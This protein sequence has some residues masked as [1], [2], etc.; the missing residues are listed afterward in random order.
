MAD[1]RAKFR[2]LLKPADVSGLDA[3]V[4][5][6]SGPY[7]SILDPDTITTIF[8]LLAKLDPNLEGREWLTQKRSTVRS[9]MAIAGSCAAM[10]RHLEFTAR[11]LY[12]ELVARSATDVVPTDKL[13]PYPYT[14]QIH[15][16]KHSSKQFKGLKVADTEM[17][18]HCSSACCAHARRIVNGKL[19]DNT[20]A[21]TFLPVDAD[22]TIR[23][24][25]PA[26]DAP[27]VYAQVCKRK[28]R[29]GGVWRN[30]RTCLQRI[31]HKRGRL[32]SA[33]IGGLADPEG[34]GLGG[35]D[36]HEIVTMAANHSGSYVAW[37]MPTTEAIDDERDGS[38][39]LFLWS[40]DREYPFQVHCGPIRQYDF[41]EG[42]YS[43]GYQSPDHPHSMWWTDEGLLVVAWT[44]TIVH[45]MGH[46]ELDGAEVD[47][48]ERYV[49][50]TYEIIPGMGSCLREAAGPF[51]GRLVSTSASYDGS[52]MVALVR[53]KPRSRG[54]TLYRAV[55]H[56]KS[57]AVELSHSHVWKGKPSKSSG[58]GGF[59]WGP[60]AV[61]IS[62]AGDS[63]V[64]VH[65]TLGTVLAEMFELE[66][67]AKYVRINAHALTEWLGMGQGCGTGDNVVKLRYRVTFSSCGRFACVTDQRAR[68]RHQF[69]GYA[70]VVMD[71]SQR[72][73]GNAIRCQ[74]L[75]YS[76]QGF[77]ACPSTGS[78]PLREVHWH[79]QRVWML[80]HRGA[81]TL[82]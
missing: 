43:W 74:P 9:V 21:T 46:D 45:P 70:S 44:S 13:V 34:T 31:E 76:D 27:I 47:P 63:I 68:W 51:Y 35:G 81:V 78:T 75:C 4:E 72:R 42:T 49:I 8:E 60:S 36:Q 32:V 18:Y 40:D 80:A 54:E 59:D 11:K 62:P 30:A 1:I 41:S 19:K 2:R 64:C 16:E 56:H 52:R 66:E 58:P 26:R 82:E 71:L 33:D 22:G 57:M 37:T 6:D 20:G 12:A 14:Q 24:I 28:V 65:R 61:G 67:G 73:S 7:F 15:S 77:E 38:L 23:S 69:T 5:Q 3:T 39:G 53:S 25:A 17:A 50:A 10:H 29:R 48:A 55:V 79:K